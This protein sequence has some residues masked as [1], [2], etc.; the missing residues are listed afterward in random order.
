[1]NNAEAQS[2]IANRSPLRG[3]PACRG[4]FDRGVRLTTA[5]AA[6]SGLWVE[7]QPQRYA[8]VLLISKSA[9]HERPRRSQP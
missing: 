6:T 2:M 5:T 4:A 7:L 1:M 3:P 8:P 9:R